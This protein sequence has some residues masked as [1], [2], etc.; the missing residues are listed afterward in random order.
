MLKS[1]LGKSVKAAEHKISVLD[2]EA[3]YLRVLKE[4]EFF[5]VVFHALLIVYDSHKFRRSDRVL[6]LGHAV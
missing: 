2:Y 4:R 1:E 5:E 6:V 3:F